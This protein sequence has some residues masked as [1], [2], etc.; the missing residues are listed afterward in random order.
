[1]TRRSCGATLGLLRLIRA[2]GGEAVVVS[3]AAAAGAS[4]RKLALWISLGGIFAGV[5]ATVGVPAAFGDGEKEILFRTPTANI[6]CHMWMQVV[7]PDPLGRDNT[8]TC[9]V[10]STASQDGYPRGLPDNYTLNANGR[11]EVSRRQWGIG[12]AYRVLRYGRS[13]R[14]GFIR[15]VSRRAGLRCVSRRSRHGFFLSRERQAAF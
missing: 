13:L 3:R 11:V 12:G 2:L 7:A 6:R 15:C 9:V 10:M 8:V 14:L 1:L 5:A 4:A